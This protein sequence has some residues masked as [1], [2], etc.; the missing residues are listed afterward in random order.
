M[1]GIIRVTFSGFESLKISDCAT[2]R[3]PGEW[4][5]EIGSINLERVAKLVPL[6][7]QPSAQF[8][9][10]GRMTFGSQSRHILE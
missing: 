5:S 10:Q 6:L 2:H 3:F 7:R 1:Q 9:D 8:G 4:D